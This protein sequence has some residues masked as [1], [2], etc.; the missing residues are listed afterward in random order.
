MPAGA[1]GKPWVLL[2]HSFLT[3]YYVNAGWQAHERRVHLHASRSVDTPQ[4]YGGVGDRGVEGGGYAIDYHLFRHYLP[5]LRHTVE[6]IVER[7]TGG[8]H[9][10]AAVKD[11]ALQATDGASPALHRYG[12]VPDGKRLDITVPSGNAAYTLDV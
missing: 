9:D 3:V 2:L 10:E 5:F 1:A 7:R 12:G 11:E 4:L 8:L 6:R